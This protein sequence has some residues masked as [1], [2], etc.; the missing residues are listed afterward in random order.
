MEDKLIRKLL[1]NVEKNQSIALA[2]VVDS[3]GSSPRGKGSMMIVDQQG[4]I[5]GGTVGG[6]A[7]EE[8]VKKECKECILKFESKLI[9]YELA[10]LPMT[11]GGNVS[12][13]IKVFNS[14][15]KLLIVG[16]GHIGTKLSQLG[17]ILNYEVTIVDNRTEFATA[18]RL[19]EADNILT[20]NIGDILRK[21][22][23]DECTSIV[24]VT[25]GHDHDLEALDAVILS[26]ARYIGMIGS[27][28][29]VIACLNSLKDNGVDEN[30]LEKIYAP[31]GLDLG[32]ETPE[33]IAL[34]ILAEL[35]AVKHRKDTNSLKYM[36]R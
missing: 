22:P 14:R 2:V 26:Q 24:I 7:I 15:D 4:N 33:E 36:M 31:I 11:C 10:S 8:K 28:G 16:A 1:D 19:P 9:N 12:V 32:G 18:D 13:F 21:Y 29:K 34:A 3:K 23:I 20:G 5:L 35:Q 17:K 6:G 30:F 27:H 25:H